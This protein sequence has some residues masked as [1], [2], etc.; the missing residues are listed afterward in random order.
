M[1][2]VEDH[3]MK[4]QTLEMPRHSTRKTRKRQGR[5][6]DEIARDIVAGG[7]RLDALLEQPVDLDETGNAQFYC[8]P[9][10]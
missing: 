3:F 8:V 7:T 4:V 2:L 1:N 5:D 9:C 6:A 10:A